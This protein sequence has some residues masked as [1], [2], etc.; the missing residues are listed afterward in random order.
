VNFFER[1]RLGVAA[2]SRDQRE[3]DDSN[4]FVHCPLLCQTW[5]KAAARILRGSYPVTGSSPSLPLVPA[6]YRI[7]GQCPLSRTSGV[8]KACCGCSNI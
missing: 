5:R 7:A 6:V 2:E 1:R 4:M 3:V 8:S